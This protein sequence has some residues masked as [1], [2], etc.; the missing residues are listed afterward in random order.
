MQLFSALVDRLP[1]FRDDANAN[2][3]QCFSIVYWATGDRERAKA[4]LREAADQASRLPAS[5]FS[6]WSYL[7]RTVNLFREDLTK[8]M[9]LYE[10]Q[11]ITPPFIERHYRKPKESL[12]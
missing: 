8:M 5:R 7:E 2:R 1:D 6:C 11:E 12:T 9:S 3:L 4:L 10:G